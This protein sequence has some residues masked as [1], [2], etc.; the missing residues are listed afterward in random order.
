MKMNVVLTLTS[1]WKDVD[2]SIHFELT[3]ANVSMA[4]KEKTAQI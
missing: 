4:T 2:A 1:V 3:A